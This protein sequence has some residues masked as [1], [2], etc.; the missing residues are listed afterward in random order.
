MDSVTLTS[1]A[2][3]QKFYT[4]QRVVFRGRPRWYVRLW[5]WLT[6]YERR[7][8]PGVLTVTGVNLVEGTV[9]V[10]RGRRP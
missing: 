6:R 5:R 2:D 1:P 3:A 10:R 7:H 8:P 4:G 9:T